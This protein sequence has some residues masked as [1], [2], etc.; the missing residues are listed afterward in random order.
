MVNLKRGKITW[1]DNRETTDVNV[2]EAPNLRDADYAGNWKAVSSR[3]GLR[4]NKLL[5]AW[6]SE[7]SHR[8]PRLTEADTL[9]TSTLFAP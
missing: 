6:S 3:T 8:A 5:F 2:A 1:T 7:G 4:Q 9:I